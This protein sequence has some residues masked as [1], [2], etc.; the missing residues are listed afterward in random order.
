MDQTWGEL[1]KQIPALVLFVVAIVLLFR[2]FLDHLKSEGADTRE[3]L[4]S[5][6]KDVRENTQ[7]CNTLTEV[8]RTRNDHGTG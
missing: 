8:M 2:M 5:L 7:A 1:A 6:G 3:V 4:R